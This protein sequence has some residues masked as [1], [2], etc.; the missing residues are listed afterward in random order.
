MSQDLRNKKAIAY[1]H[2]MGL[3]P[4]HKATGYLILKELRPSS[5]A[6]PY[7]YGFAFYKENI[8]NIYLCVNTFLRT[9]I[10]K[11]SRERYYK[12]FYPYLSSL[13]SSVFSSETGSLFNSFSNSARNAA[14]CSSLRSSIFVSGFLL[15]LRT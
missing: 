6:S 3:F 15:C 10:K 13:G 2:T 9:Y 7:H 8:I 12:H 1:H 11:R 14:F 4:T 5:F